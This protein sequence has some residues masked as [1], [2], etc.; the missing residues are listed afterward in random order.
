MIT[1]ARK[2]LTLL[3]TTVALALASM[4]VSGLVRV[5]DA[6][7]RGT[8]RTVDSADAVRS[9][10]LAVEALR[11]DATRMVVQ[12][13]GDLAIP[14]DGRGISM[15]VP[16]SAPGNDPWAFAAV[17]VTFSLA[18]VATPGKAFELVRSGPDGVRHIRGCWLASLVVRRRPAGTLS[19]T[20]AFLEFCVSAVGSPA[21]G[22][23][24][25]MTFVVPLESQTI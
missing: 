9:G 5:T 12:Q 18:P 21:G 8:V 4:A 15:L 7:L 20:R 3:E 23:A 17:P 6:G 16:A 10:L 2:G 24:C 13:A 11:A 1:R 19:P 25:T 14:T 22:K